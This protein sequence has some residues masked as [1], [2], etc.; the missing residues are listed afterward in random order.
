MRTKHIKTVIIFVLLIIASCQLYNI[1]FETHTAEHNTSGTVPPWLKNEFAVNTPVITDE[2]GPVMESR[3]D[4]YG[5]FII[6]F[7]DADTKELIT[8]KSALNELVSMFTYTE[9]PFV[10]D[11][12]R[13]RN[14][15]C[16]FYYNGAVP[17]NHAVS[18]F[19]GF[20]GTAKAGLD[21][22]AAKGI[23]R[24][25]M[26]FQ[27]STIPASFSDDLEEALGQFVPG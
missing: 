24:F 17:A 27:I 7:Y 19:S 20:N 11:Q 10:Y 22:G 15:G 2:P 16:F 13:T 21:P 1:F 5:A 12:T 9:E 8:D 23:N 18:L 25:Y 3:N 4:Y 14:G 26:K 6:R